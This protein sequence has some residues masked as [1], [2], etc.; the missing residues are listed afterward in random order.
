MIRPPATLRIGS[1]RQQTEY[2]LA[3]DLVGKSS[4]QLLPEDDV[5]ID[6]KQLDC[7]VVKDSACGAMRRTKSARPVYRVGDTDS[8]VIP[9]GRLFVRLAADSRIDEKTD[10]L[11]AFGLE[12]DKLNL[13]APNTGWVRPSD[14]DVA[15]ALA[16]IDDVATRLVAHVEPELVGVSANRSSIPQ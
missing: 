9:T 14:N 13:W 12:I 4:E 5:V 8:V 6:L 3:D 7:I 2:T 1:V 11:K 16:E 10:E 15:R